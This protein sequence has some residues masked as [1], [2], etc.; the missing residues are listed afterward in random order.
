MFVSRKWIGALCLSASSGLASP[1]LAQTALEPATGQST[2][3]R[4]RTTTP[5]QPGDPSQTL[6]GSVPRTTPQAVPG[7]RANNGANLNR[8]IAV[9]ILLGNEEEVALGQFAESRAQHPEVKKFAQQMVEHHRQVIQ[10]VQ[11]AA[12]ETVDHNLQLKSTTNPRGA[13]ST[14]PLS[15]TAGVRT[16]SAETPVAGQPADHNQQGVQLAQA[17]KQECLNLTEQE[18]AQKQ[19]VEFDKAYIGQ[20][21]GAH[22][23][24]LAQLRGSRQFASG[25]LKPLIDEGEKM[26]QQH[27]DQAKQLMAQLKDKQG[28]S[29][30][31]TAQRP[32]SPAQP[33]R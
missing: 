26:T 30:P 15:E 22:M 33:T 31:P 13:A 1:A 11:Q 20:Q 21:I 32:A 23:G 4:A 24:M 28:A 25:E 3:E 6:P 12:P 5:G 18:L 10:K 14:T 27:L 8:E 7:G 29:T 17:I 16:A 9:W 2:V 19:G